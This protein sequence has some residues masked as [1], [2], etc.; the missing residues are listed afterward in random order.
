VEANRN[1]IER[2]AYELYEQGINDDM[3]ADWQQA[4]REVLCNVLSGRIAAY[5]DYPGVNQSASMK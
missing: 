3:Q 4:E 5:V 1:K 2:R